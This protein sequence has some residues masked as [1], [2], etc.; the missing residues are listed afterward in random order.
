M[1]PVNKK[2]NEEEFKIFCRNLFFIIY[3]KNVY[4][5]INISKPFMVIFHYF[6]TDSEHRLR[7]LETTTYLTRL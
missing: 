2:M 4:L 3:S 5:R 6:K 7:G 1:G